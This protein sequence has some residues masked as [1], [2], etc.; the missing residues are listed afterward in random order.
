MKFEET[1]PFGIEIEAVGVP[2]AT[3]AAELTA[4]GIPTEIEHYNHDLRTYWKIVSDATI[5]GRSPFELVSP[6]LYGQEGLD[7]VRKVMKIVRGLGGNVNSSCGLHV[8]HSAQGL[9][10][11]QLRMVSH[12]YSSLFSAFDG[13]FSLSRQH[14]R[15]AQLADPQ[16]VN[17]MND[18]DMRHGNRYMAVNLMAFFK[19]GTIEFRQHQGSLNGDKALS[20]IVFTQQFMLGALHSKVKVS[21]RTKNMRVGLFNFWRLYD[22]G[23]TI[24]EPCEKMLRFVA[25]RASWK[26]GKIIAARNGHDEVGLENGII[27]MVPVPEAAIVTTDP[28]C[29]VAPDLSGETAQVGNRFQHMV[30]CEVCTQA[31]ETEAQRRAQEVT[32]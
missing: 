28:S 32:A 30:T 20:W 5:R 16:S 17:R 8:H 21:W 22:E 27:E 15:W 4:Q 1:R 23:E 31:R 10:S 24:D 11:K 14:S 12:F 19:H 25:K 7:E 2:M 18:V 3:L 6:K 9:N 29:V 26:V 13:I